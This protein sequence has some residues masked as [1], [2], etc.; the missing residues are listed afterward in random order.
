MVAQTDNSGQE[1]GLG[2]EPALSERCSRGGTEVRELC[3]TS[4]LCSPFIIILPLYQPT[5]STVNTYV[6]KQP[7]HLSRPVS[8]FIVDIENPRKASA[9]SSGCLQVSLF[10]SM[11]SHFSV[12]FLP[13]EFREAITPFM[14][15]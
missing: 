13:G 5:R 9:P 15:T 2:L 6:D 4:P 1:I 12:P 3:R 8:H 7:H 11:F 10:S 14:S